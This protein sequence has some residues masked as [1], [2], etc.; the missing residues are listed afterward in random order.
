MNESERL[1]RK[2]TQS[3]PLIIAEISSNHNQYLERARNLVKEA[4]LAGATAVKFQ[5]FEVEKLFSPEVLQT[6]AGHRS[7]KG[8]ELPR[9][10]VPI[11][12]NDARELGMLFGCTPFDFDAAEFLVPYVDFFK[13]ASYELLWCDLLSYCGASQIPVILSTGMATDPEVWNAVE[14]LEASGCSDYALLHCVSSYPAPREETNL[15]AISAMRQRFRVPAGW[16][17][18]TNDVSVVLR[19]INRWGASIIEL[20]FDL[21]GKGYEAGNGHCWLPQD[22]AHLTETLEKD[23]LLDG[24]GTKNPTEAELSDVVWRTDPND[25][26][27]PLLGKRQNLWD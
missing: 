7:R 12:A 15:S 1:L 3:A 9:D 27:R 19:A 17:D 26:L 20:H 24:N 22:L 2:P 14:C 11:L 23:L 6:S 21:D 18:H 8:W 25:G 4:S 16:S 5:L 13:I 10:F